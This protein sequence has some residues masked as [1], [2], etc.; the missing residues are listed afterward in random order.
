MRLFTALLL[1][2][3]LTAT[4]N[5]QSTKKI[6]DFPEALTLDAADI[7]LLTVNPGGTPLSKH[8]KLSTLQTLLDGRTGTL[9]GKTISGSNNTFSNIPYSALTG[10]PVAGTDYLAPNGNGSS[11]TGLTKAQ[12]GLGNVDN[13]S[14]ADKPI[15]AATQDAMDDKADAAALTS[16]TG[17]TSN[18][19]N[20]TKSQVGLGNV[21]NTSDANKPIST[22]TQTALDAKTAR[23]TTTVD[24]TITRFDGTSG[25][26]QG[27]AL[28]IEDAAITP[29]GFVRI[30]PDDGTTANM[31]IVLGRKGTGP[32][33]VV[34]AAPDGTTTGGN[35]RGDGA[36][37]LGV[38]HTA[39]DHAATGQY[40]FRA[41]MG[42]VC[43]ALGAVAILGAARWNYAVSIGRQ[44][45]ANQQYTYTAGYQSAATNYGQST[46]ASG[47]FSAQGDAQRTQWTARKVTTN[48]T[49]TD[50]ALDGNTTYFVIPI[51]NVI[52]GTA[53]IVGTKADGTALSTFERQFR[54]KRVGSTSSLVGSVTTIGADHEDNASTDVAITVND[55]DET[56]RITVTGIASETWRWV[57]GFEGVQMAAGT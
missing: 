13:T 11:L 27:S 6:G 19:H 1:F 53:R 56:I 22:A 30:T 39:A 43:N 38:L 28:I 50:V 10:A 32:A 16:H 54:A 4:G 9:A 47:Q 3:A 41:P 18:P 12:V 48:N 35:A 34:G 51:G 52:F 2:A 37:D 24:N 49:P 5:A 25:G 26:Q 36:V 20:V 57:V 7:F 44:C 33:L 31:G 8:A 14:D 46:H 29:Q 40:S 17:N 21:D 45:N 15:S 23:V 55:S 42:E